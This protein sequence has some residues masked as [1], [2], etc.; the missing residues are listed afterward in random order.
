MWRQAPSQARPPEFH[1]AHGSLRRRLPRAT[2]QPA[3]WPGP[4]PPGCLWR[5]AAEKRPSCLLLARLLLAM[6]C[7]IPSDLFDAIDARINASGRLLLQL[8]MQ[9][10]AEAACS[11]ASAAENHENKLVRSQWC[12]VCGLCVRGAAWGAACTTIECPSSCCYRPHQPDS[13]QPCAFAG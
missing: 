3:G 6:C 4:A 9:G 11:A 5:L 1:A 2:G 8:P 12:G 10:Q 7:L 13:L